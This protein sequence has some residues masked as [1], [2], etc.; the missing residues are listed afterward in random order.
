[1]YLCVAYVCLMPEEA[2]REHLRP[3]NLVTDGC[4]LPCGYWVLNSAP[5]E[6][7]PA[8]LITELSLSPLYEIFSKCP[9]SILSL[10]KY[11][12]SLMI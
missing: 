6:E 9:V 3:W 2:R 1:M 4:E 12:V 10:H 7:Q 5:L 8:L 11:E